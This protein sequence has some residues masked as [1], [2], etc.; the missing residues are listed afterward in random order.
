MKAIECLLITGYFL[1]LVRP[2]ASGSSDEIV[3]PASITFE[4]EVVQQMNGEEGKQTMT[5]CFSLNGDYAAIKP[6]MGDRSSEMS[7]MVYTKDGSILMFND[8]RKTIT[9]IRAAKLV[10]DG[11]AMSKE[12]AES[13]SDKKLPVTTSKKGDFKVNPTG[14]A[15]NICGYTALEYEMKSAEGKSLWYYGKHLT[16][17]IFE[18]SRF[19]HIGGFS[20]LWHGIFLWHPYIADIIY[21]RFIYA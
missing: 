13:K 6:G 3:I 20:G 19:L 17:P 16:G 9:V 10:A 5:Y 12:L 8:T 15:I 1:S 18:V 2:I 4:R 7:L 11:A 14:K 21:H